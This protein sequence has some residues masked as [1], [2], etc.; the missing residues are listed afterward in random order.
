MDQPYEQSAGRVATSF[1]L[2]LQ[3]GHSRARWT[4]PSDSFAHLRLEMASKFFA[5]TASYQ[6]ILGII[7][8]AS[9]P[10]NRQVLGQLLPSVRGAPVPLAV[11]SGAAFWRIVV[12]ASCRISQ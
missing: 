11:T 5:S 3:A 6:A 12:L 4:E 9:I 7:S 2:P 8:S 1:I 10:L